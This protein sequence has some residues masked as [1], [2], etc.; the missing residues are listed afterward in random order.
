MNA[1]PA[2]FQKGNLVIYHNAPALVSRLADSKV[3]IELIDGKTVKVRNSDILFLHPGPLASLS[4]LKILSAE[5]DEARELFGEEL[6]SLADLAELLYGE[7]SPQSAWTVYTL[8]SEGLYLQGTLDR[9]RVRSR[10]EVEKDLAVRKAKADEKKAWA[11]FIDELRSGRVAEENKNRLSD[12]EHFAL[13]KTQNSSILKELNMTATPENAHRLL[14]KVKAWNPLK[15]PYPSRLGFETCLKYPEMPVMETSSEERLDLTH[16]PAYAI[17]DEGNKD[18]DDAISID[19]NTL[20]VHIADVA[21]LIDPDSP[22][23]LHARSVGT[24]LYLP[25]SITTMLSPA[26]TDFLGLG[27]K[28]TSP[29]LSFSLTLNSEGA[30][31]TAEIHLTKVKVTR[32]TY[33]QAEEKLKDSPFQE[34]FSMTQKYR[35]NRKKR[36]ANFL[37]FPEVKIQVKDN[38]VSI[39]P[40]TPFKSREMVAEA[41]IMASEAAANFAVEH[42][43]PFPFTT[44]PAPDSNDHPETLAEMF[45]FRRLLKP[46]VIKS[47]P[48]IHA[49]LG[50]KAYSRVTSPLR[51]YI[52]LL[53][54]QQLRLFLHKKPVMDEQTIL[55]KIGAYNAVIHTTQKLE[56]LSNQHWTLVYLIQNPQWK[57]E[58]IVVENRERFS[59]VLIPGLG[60]ETRINLSQDLPLNTPVCLSVSSVDLPDLSAYFQI[61]L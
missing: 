30:L 29:A 26:V 16:L 42:S 44:Q 49:G 1:S 3:E 12:L 21:S 51:R 50:V 9:I 23:D 17:D 24:T 37:S 35:E 20:W 10:E 57:G 53:A 38:L 54:H 6:T 25:E 60:M 39:K 19:G 2:S 11:Q 41:M 46:S 36:N 7:F 32:L 52:D 45:A 5:T 14:L 8:L 59:I 61:S 27:L 34:I 47:G 22:A 15:N 33:A 58:G 28:E 31:E 55:H 4:Q 18:P 43:L 48:D 40:L 56:R 13:G